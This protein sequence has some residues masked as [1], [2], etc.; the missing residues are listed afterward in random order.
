MG[1]QYHHIQK[2]Q[3]CLG[4]L[5]GFDCS[6]DR[7]GSPKVRSSR[8]QMFYKTGVP[9][10]FAK[11]TRKRRYWSLFLVKLQAFMPGVFQ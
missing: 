11:F 8:Q 7:K 1:Q 3:I 6:F 10:I 4:Y 9:K 2:I 5:A